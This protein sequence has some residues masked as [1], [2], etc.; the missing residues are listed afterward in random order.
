MSDITPD[1]ELAAAAVT[2]TQELQR[3]EAKLDRILAA[4]GATP[5]PPIP[6]TPTPPPPTPPTN[7]QA[8]YWINQSQGDLADADAGRIVAALN[9]QAAA[10]VGAW[11]GLPPV[12]HAL[13]TGDPAAIPKTAWKM[14]WLPDADTAGALGYHDTD[15]H[16][17]PYGRVFTRYQGKAWPALRPESHG[18]S[19]S[20]ISSHEAVEIQVDPGCQATATAPNGD[21]WALEDADPVEAFAY[22]LTLPSG[23][24]VSMS[25]FVTAAFFDLPA[26]PGQGYD[27]M[28]K[29]SKPFAIS[30]GGYA[31]V[32]NKQVFADEPSLRYLSQASS[33]AGRTARRLAAAVNV[34]GTR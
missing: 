17:T 3:V 30:P 10:L 11:P 21:V 13:W 5:P 32:N 22:D 6:P 26:N 18:I 15:P 7:L 19:I 14:Y 8:V 25:D 31:I 16:G 28:S 27:A 23:T 9:V 20:N 1:A 24:V 12:A 2:Y 29:A 4:V 33:P 34:I